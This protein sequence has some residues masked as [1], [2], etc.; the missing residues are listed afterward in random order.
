M[1]VFPDGST[2]GTVGGG[3][4]ESRVT[5]A[6]LGALQSGEPC[7]IRVRLDGEESVCGGEVSV[8]IEPMIESPVVVMVG[9]GHVG[10]SVTEAAAAAGFRIVVLDDRR[11][12]VE[13]VARRA[14]VLG[15]VG[16]IGQTL[17]AMDLGGR[18]HVV[19]ATRGHEHD[20]E[21]LRSV[22]QQPVGYIGMIGS[23]AK[24]RHVLAALHSEGFD[25][26][27]LRRVRAPVGLDIGA[28]TPGEIAASIVAEII[29]VRRGGTGGSLRE[30]KG[31]RGSG[32]AGE[33]GS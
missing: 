16:P 11:G 28:E 27:E 33:Q 31:W 30:L 14:G 7:L 32:G 13:R 29:M 17:A 15:I 25:A 20:E 10:T 24:V 19:I 26:R 3:P 18:H 1:L 21:A 22:V 8:F 9:A 6:A 5:E 23:R 12:A 4:G 2:T